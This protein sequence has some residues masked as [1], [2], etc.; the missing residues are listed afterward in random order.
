[1]RGSRTGRLTEASS[2]S[3]SHGVRGRRRERQR[4][5]GCRPCPPR[6][7]RGA[8]RG[9]PRLLLPA[10]AAGRHDGL[11][12]TALNIIPSGQLGAVPG[13]GRRRPAGADVRRAD[14]AASTTSRATTST[15]DFKSERFGTKGQ[16]P[17]R[18]GEG[19]AQRRAPRARQASTS[20]T[21]RPRPTTRSRGRRAGSSPRTAGCC[22]SRRATTRALAAIDAPNLSAI[23]LIASV[24]TFTP[25]A[26]TE[27]E[28]ARQTRVI[29]AAG[30]RGRRLLHDID[31]YVQGHQ[32]PAAGVE[33]RGEA[34]DAH[35]TST[36]SNALKGQFLGQGGGDEARR[37][38]SSPGSSSASG[39]QSGQLV[40]DDLRQ[41]DPAD[42][43]A[44]I[45]GTFPYAT[46]PAS[47]AGQRDRRP[48]LAAAV[49]LRRR[50]RHAVA[51]RRGASLPTA[52]PTARPPHASNVLMVSGKPLDERPPAVRRRPADRL[53]LPRP[54]ARDGH[55]RAG[56]RRARRDLGAVPR[57][58]A[59]SAAGP[60]SRGRSPRPAPTSSTSSSRRSAAA[61]TRTTCSRASAGR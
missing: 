28:V 16:C 42:H 26:Q 58:H 21:S 38:S 57:L 39:R 44:S 46:V 30:T 5:V 24:R 55:A 60:T 19:P 2:S 32:R 23:G 40:F 13:P 59:A 8:R 9:G 7:P 33:E 14:P 1:M 3:A 36:R 48:E 43:P 49:A 18:V 15:R 61:T 31:I 52:S 35:A 54:D 53:L 4:L 6:A 20:R 29:R 25:S 37:S 27:T 45:G 47:K 34:V 12:V 22:S 50:R 17:C 41:R 11:R 10:S 56:H 51:A